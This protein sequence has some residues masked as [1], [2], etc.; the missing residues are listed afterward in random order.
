MVLNPRTGALG[1]GP[2]VLR[3]EHVMASAHLDV[4]SAAEG[5][6]WEPAAAAEAGLPGP[7]ALCKI[8]NARR[9]AEAGLEQ[10]TDSI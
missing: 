6:L 9:R 2:R 5:R 1:T 10:S 8:E 3:F 7:D 4:P